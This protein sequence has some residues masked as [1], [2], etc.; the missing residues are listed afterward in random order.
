MSA[1][2]PQPE[3]PG[4]RQRVLEVLSHTDG[5]PTASTDSDY[6]SAVLDT[7]AHLSLL[8]SLVDIPRSEIVARLGGRWEHQQFPTA[9][10]EDVQVAANTLKFMTQFTM[11]HGG[12]GRIA[13]EFAL[14]IAARTVELAK[15][16]TL[17][18][19]YIVDSG[20]LGPV[21]AAMGNHDYGEANSAFETF[22]DQYSTQEA[23]TSIK[24]GSG[25]TVLLDPTVVRELTQVVL[26][27]EFIEPMGNDET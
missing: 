25:R 23:P 2:V 9:S 10:L 24:T 16:D 3:V 15:Y 27:G 4:L 5:L 13:N 19:Q 22:A 17:Q 14:N 7:H 12:L 6:R 11:M 20:K 18:A 26:T 21:T 1:E 8:A